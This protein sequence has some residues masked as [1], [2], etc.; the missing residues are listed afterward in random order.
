MEKTLYFGSISNASRAKRLLASEHVRA[1]LTKLETGTEGCTWG[2]RLDE[3][4]LL[5][6]IQILRAEGV[7]YEVR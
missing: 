1:R 4:D 6:A 5:A 3:S 7:R 2:L